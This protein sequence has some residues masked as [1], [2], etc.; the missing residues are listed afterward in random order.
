MR[1]VKVRQVRESSAAMQGFE[2]TKAVQP[3]K[4][5]EPYHAES[6]AI[7][8]PP[9][10]EAVAGTDRKPAKAAPASPAKSNPESETASK[11]KK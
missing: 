10:E 11:S 4:S 7:T 2:S 9:W 1:V 3:A 6:P 5:V 8:A